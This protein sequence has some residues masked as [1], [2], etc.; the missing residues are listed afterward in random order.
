M[1]PMD[2]KQLSV[3]RPYLAEQLAQNPVRMLEATQL[4]IRERHQLVPSRLSRETPIGAGAQDLP[5]AAA[6]RHISSHAERP[7]SCC[8]V[9]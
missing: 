7:G 1:T 4:H 5:Q 8:S 6:G 3:G 9:S 2:Q